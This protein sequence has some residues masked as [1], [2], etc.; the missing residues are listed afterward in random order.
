MEIQTGFMV[1]RTVTEVQNDVGMTSQIGYSRFISQFGNHFT[2][3][4]YKFDGLKHYKINQFSC[5]V[6]STPVTMAIMYKFEM[7][8]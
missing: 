5:L 7:C 6:L 3:I 8:Y 2:K 1:S 4:R